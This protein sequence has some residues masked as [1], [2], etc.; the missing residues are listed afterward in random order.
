MSDPKPHK[1]WVQMT[2]EEKR[3][4]AF[5]AMSGEKVQL[6]T[7]GYGWG[8]WDGETP[9]CE[10]PFPIR[11][12][13]KP[14]RGKVILYGSLSGAYFNN[15]SELDTHRITFD[16]LDGKLPVGTYINENGDIVKIEEMKR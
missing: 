13:P 2:K 5:R 4:I 9:F 8:G 16:T 1:T 3:E 7:Q 11:I 10:I 14:K 12:R 15:V 6:Y